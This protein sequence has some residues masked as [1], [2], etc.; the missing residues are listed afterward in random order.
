MGGLGCDNMT[1][2]IAFFLHG[3]TFSELT[4]Q[5]LELVASH[6]SKGEEQ[7]N[8]DCSSGDLGCVEGGTAEAQRIHSLPSA[9]VSKLCSDC[10][11]AATATTSVHSC[12]ASEQIN[13]H[14]EF[15]SKGV[16]LISAVMVGESEFE[17]PAI[18]SDTL[19][20]ETAV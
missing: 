4:V 2:V 15:S 13:S 20:I 19:P 1:L 9:G 8:G 10:S 17:D 6:D 5:C 11:A 16:D 3:R 14:E 12:C 7:N 18:E